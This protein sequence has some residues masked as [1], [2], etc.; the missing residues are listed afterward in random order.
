MNGTA[1]VPSSVRA[2]SDERHNIVER[3]PKQLSVAGL[4][5]GAFRQRPDDLDGRRWLDEHAE[6]RSIRH[7]DR[8]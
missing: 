3:S 8:G 4:R 2:S 1:S 5:T 6:Y 7:G